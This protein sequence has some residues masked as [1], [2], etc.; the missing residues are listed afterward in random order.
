MLNKESGPTADGGVA[1]EGRCGSGGGR[2]LGG[3]VGGT[4]AQI[5]ARAR[6]HD[7][8]RIYIYIYR[9]AHAL[10]YRMPLQYSRTR[11]NTER[12]RW[13]LERR[14]RFRS[15]L[16]RENHRRFARSI[17]RGSS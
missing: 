13:N 3:R 11:F 1:L 2:I 7:H 14:A 17:F 6:A 12:E 15:R 16:A 10:V 8:T 5:T 4:I 9:R